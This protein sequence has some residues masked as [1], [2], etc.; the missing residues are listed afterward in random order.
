MKIG[1]VIKLNNGKNAIVYD[2]EERYFFAVDYKT[3]FYDI[4]KILVLEDDH[5]EEVVKEGVDIDQINQ[6]NLPF[7]LTRRNEIG[8]SLSSGFLP[9]GSIIKT[10]HKREEYLIM[11]RNLI[12]GYFSYNYVGYNSEHG[13]L[14]FNTKDI[15]KVYYSAGNLE[16]LNYKPKKFTDE[17]HNLKFYIKWLIYLLLSSI[18]FCFSLVSLQEPYFGIAQLPII[19]GKLVAFLVLYQFHKSKVLTISFV[20][21]MFFVYAL[22]VAVL[23]R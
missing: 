22:Q 23:L 10:K 4:N 16:Q 6:D 13:W 17:V 18:I 12:K 7:D 3:G 1:T 20:L 2:R 21:L 14:L 19:F 15:E 8:M 5:I 11:G 9:L